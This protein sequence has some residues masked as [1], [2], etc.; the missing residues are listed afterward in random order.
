MKTH[1]HDRPLPFGIAAAKA[2]EV[3]TENLAAASWV[4]VVIER[5]TTI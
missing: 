4:W 1:P 5:L 2:G 3:R